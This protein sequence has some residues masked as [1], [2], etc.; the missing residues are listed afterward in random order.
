MNA[1]EA[2]NVEIVVG[3]H[4]TF[5]EVGMERIRD[6]LTQRLS[7]DEWEKEGGALVAYV[8][9]HINPDI[10]I[11]VLATGFLLPDM[12]RERRFHGLGGWNEFWHAWLEP[13]DDWWQE[14]T[15]VEAIGDEVVL[16]LE[17]RARGRESGVPMSLKSSQVW[18]V[19]DER[20]ARVRLY[21]DREQAESAL[22]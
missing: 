21:D 1:T 19:R 22:W 16:D 7:R 9:E 2:R 17:I 3:L 8:A 20:I 13:W 12:P 6:A 5:A 14:T 11:E 18:T 15:N 10:E 4:Q